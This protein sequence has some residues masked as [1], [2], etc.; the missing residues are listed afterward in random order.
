MVSTNLSSPTCVKACYGYQGQWYMNISST[1]VGVSTVHGQCCTWMGSAQFFFKG[2]YELPCVVVL[3][4]TGPSCSNS[5]K[6][7]PN[8]PVLELSLCFSGYLWYL[9]EFT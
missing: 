3:F 5:F 8:T 6:G 2:V 7:V 1:K 4:F 9:M